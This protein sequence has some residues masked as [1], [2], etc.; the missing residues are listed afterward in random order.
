MNDIPAESAGKPAHLST[1]GAFSYTCH[2]CRRCCSGKRIWVNPYEVYRLS[3]RLGMTTTGFI[4][5]HTVNGGTELAVR[6]DLTCVFLGEQGC[7]VHSD[8]P[9][10]CRLYPLGRVVQSGE[11]DRYFLMEPHPQSEGVYSDAGSV[12]GYLEQQGAAP[13]MAAADEY[14]ALLERVGAVLSEMDPP[15]AELTAV[16]RTAADVT[17]TAAGVVEAGESAV[18]PPHSPW[19]DIDA[20]LASEI[21]VTEAG[22]RDVP[23]PF[24]AEKA[25][26]LHI[27]ALDRWHQEVSDTLTRSYEA[28]SDH[29]A[30]DHIPGA[31]P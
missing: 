31:T 12:G 25:M 4:E 26:A 16:E 20:V 30:S 10:V 19:L 8:R 6:D 11:P 21:G 7:G 3:R 15:G 18:V 17:S 2:R 5:Q 9:L 29:D 22:A 28:P 13:F 1:D 23:R 14:F 24:G 27:A